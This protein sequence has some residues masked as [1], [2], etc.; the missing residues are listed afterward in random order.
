MK[1]HEPD[2]SG[3][4]V[5][6]RELTPPRDERQLSQHV[7]CFE[8]SSDIMLTLAA[9]H[10]H[11]SS[12]PCRRQK[13]GT[14]RADARAR[15]TRSNRK[16]QASRQRRMKV[17]SPDNKVQC[18]NCNI[19]RILMLGLDPLRND[20]KARRVDQE[21]RR[22]NNQASKTRDKHRRQLSSH[23]RPQVDH[24]SQRLT[25][26]CCEVEFFQEQ[27]AQSDWWTLNE[28]GEGTW[29]ILSINCAGSV[30]HH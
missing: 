25:A 29:T 3:R 30:V 16:E 10:R 4:Y 17:R 6:L 14:A 18:V 15:L 20:G 9:N 8:K 27:S 26:T 12:E 28:A 5:S 7:R 19:S 1:A 21:I 2:T 24:C 23:R 22:E 13:H 11:G